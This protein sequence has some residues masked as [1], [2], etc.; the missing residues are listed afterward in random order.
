MASAQRQLNPYPT[1]S[2]SGRRI[3]L[4]TD[5]QLA[6]ARSFTKVGNDVLYAAP[7]A[8]TRI[9]NA[10]DLTGAFLALP[11]PPVPPLD[12]QWVVDVQ[13]V[14]GLLFTG[15]D[16][17]DTVSFNAALQ[18]SANEGSTF[19]QIDPAGSAGALN[20]IGQVMANPPAFRQVVLAVTYTA[21]PV[22]VLTSGVQ[23][24]TVWNKT[25]AT[26]QVRSVVYGEA[27]SNSYTL[28]A[29]WGLV[30]VV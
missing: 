14:M 30:P 24:Q 7:D 15:D 8:S 3:A 28:H 6:L 17:Y 11:P 26:Q 20:F 25:V 2:P 9:V 4:N 13:F 16:T 23:L 19:A 1:Q 27:A 10:S 12:W 22:A 29:K 5:Q 21:D 18:A